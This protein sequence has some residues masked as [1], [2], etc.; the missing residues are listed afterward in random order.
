MSKP[1]LFLDIDGPLHPTNAP[2]FDLVTGMAKGDRLFRWLPKLLEIL[3][4]FPT[5]QVVLHSSWRYCWKTEEEVRDNLPD[6]LN[7]IIVATT[8]RDIK[9]RY[10]SI[11]H[12]CKINN[13]TKYVILD[14]DGNAFPYGVKELVHCMPSQG[15]SRQS[16]YS[17]LIVKLKE[18]TEIKEDDKN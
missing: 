17:K 14:D 1:T 4:Q 16:T 10:G 13:I 8:G 18:I 6:A 9:D 15:L 12:F 5:V 3:S 11:L 7:A 2:Y